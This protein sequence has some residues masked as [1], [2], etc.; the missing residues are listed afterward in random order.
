VAGVFYISEIIVGRV[1]KSVAMRFMN[2]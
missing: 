2:K 1:K